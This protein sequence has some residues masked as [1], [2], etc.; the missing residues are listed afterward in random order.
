MTISAVADTTA[1]SSSA[2]ASARLSDNYDTFLLLLTAQLQNQDPLSPMDSTQ[3]TEQL[4]QYSQ[5]EQQI[6]T[7]DQLGSL[8]AHYQAASAGAALAYLGRDAVIEGDDAPLAGG[9]AQWGYALENNASRVTLTVKNAAGKTV[10]ERPGETTAGDHAFTW[11]G[12]NADGAAQP[13][14]LYTLEI[15]AADADDAAVASKIT[16]REQ[17]MGVDFSGSA[18]LVITKSGTHGMD[19]VRAILDDD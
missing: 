14:G 7:N 2:D 5:V 18:P 12:R 17:I 13:D 6:R 16:V 19:A 8:V 10:F 15:S 4:V 11:D 1:L 9:E 3:F